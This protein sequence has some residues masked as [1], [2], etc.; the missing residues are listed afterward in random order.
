[1][2]KKIIFFVWMFFVCW[3]G[4]A[5]WV[6]GQE[7][8]TLTLEIHYIRQ[9]EDYEGWNLWLWQ[10]GEEGQ[11]YP[12][13]VEEGGA[14]S[15]ITLD[16]VDESA[17]I[18][19]LI[20]KGE[21]EEK[22]I[23]EDRFLDL[24]QMK[25]GHLTVWLWQGAETITYG[26]EGEA[27]RIIDACLESETEL[28]F[29]GLA[30]SD[31]SFQVVDNHGKEYELASQEVVQNDYLLS[32][33]LTLKEAVPL[34]NTFYLVV[35]DTKQVIRFGG[36]YDTPLFTD[37]FVYDGDDLGVVCEADKSVFKLWAP[38]AESVTLLLYQEGEG[39]NL[40]RSEPLSYTEKGVF[41]VTLSGDYANQYYT[42]L[43]NVQGSEWEVVDPYAKSAGVNGG[44]G[45]ILAKDEGMPEGFKEDTFIR[46][47]KREDVILYEMSVRDYTSDADSGVY[48]KGKFLGLT[49][50]N[51]VNSAGD[52][53]GLSYLAGLG[54]THVHFLPIQD[55]Y[56]VD[57]KEPWE[58]YN[59][60]YNPVNYFVP[61][62]SYATD[63]YHG[64]VRVRE[65]REM[66][67]SIHGQGIGVIMDVVYNH[68]YYSADSN[69]NRIVPGYY[70]RI[71]EDGSYSNGSKCGNELATERA[72]VRKYIID[73]V[74]YWMQEYHV[75]GFRFDLMGLMDVE[76]MKEIEKEVYRI[77]P[78]AVLYGEGWDAGETIYEGERMESV[79]AYLTPGIGTFNNVFRRAVQKYI[80]GIV[81]EE[82]TILGMEFG[83]AGAGD[84]PDTVARMGT[85]TAKPL[86]C[87]NYASCHDGYTL[88]DLI[89]LNCP[90][91]GQALLKRRDRFGAACVLLCQGT[92]F[93]H[94]GEEF[95]R[96]K[97]SPSNPDVKYGAS[98]AAGDEVNGLD[99]KNRTENK[100]VLEYYRGLIAFRKEHSGLC[101]ATQRQLNKNLV[102]IEELPENVMGYYAREPI[103]FFM[104]YQICLLFNPTQEAVE[105]L[106][107]SGIWEIYVDDQ[108]AGTECLEV[109]AEGEALCVE[110]VS[111]LAAVRTVVRT[112]RIAILIAVVFLAMA[113]VC[114]VLKK[115]RRKKHGR[116]KSGGDDQ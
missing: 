49:E 102:F 12:F 13:Q 11:A 96:T 83:F 72:M 46:D 29:R 95:L 88:W 31:A 79:N 110:G 59:W 68:T 55:F 6:F 85:W 63:P 108:R 33:K 7:E 39:D 74:K 70:H 100:D 66:I 9:E 19:I 78:H 37:N 26:E 113:V 111:A 48:H 106:P 43:V 56:G 44:R 112:D 60:G 42:Y 52:S 3:M 27:V 109:A 40:L 104:D 77:N 32:G 61:E 65:L 4:A 80:C 86:Q 116:N 25:D 38:M 87:I 82:S 34:P 53:T 98:Y 51:T 115:S 21:W 16:H 103:N 28:V 73:S 69:F 17:R 23:D 15:R 35:G 10:E 76:T 92:P 58:S 50:E 91:E 5:A 81:E 71:K 93:L 54:I 84:H 101:Y 105:F 2:G 47:I 41:S 22:D 24:S 30:P 57:E 97:V 107:A 8:E 14:C 90:E 36:I 18:G 20:R 99:W 45:M 1:M 89:S 94:S 67:Q 114:I 62:G 64:E 75:D